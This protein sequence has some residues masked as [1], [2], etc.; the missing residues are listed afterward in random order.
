MSLYY[1]QLLDNQ[2]PIASIDIINPSIALPG[3]EISFTGSGMD[4]DGFVSNY[5]WSSSID[6]NLSLADNFTISN[7]TMGLHTISFL[8]Q[9]N[10]GR[11]SHPV[12]M[13]I[14]VGDFPEVSILSVLN[15]PDISNCIV[16]LDD[17]VSIFASANSTTSEDISIET[18][19][20]ISSL[21][22][23]IS[24]NLNFFV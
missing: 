11:W 21:D 7:L 18:F 24:N 22:G 6:G 12:T 4:I 8:V 10:E 2:A 16:S 23:S 20:W 15:C 9:D 19:E 3:E 17:E 13:E 14:G 1:E 5:H